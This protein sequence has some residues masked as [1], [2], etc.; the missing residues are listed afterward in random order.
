MKS[1]VTYADNKAR[2]PLREVNHL[3][4]VI[5]ID[6]ITNICIAL[7]RQ[8]PR[9]ALPGRIVIWMDTDD[10]AKNRATCGAAIHVFLNQKGGMAVLPLA[11]RQSVLRVLL[12]HPPDLVPDAPLPFPP[13]VRE[14]LALLILGLQEQVPT[15]GLQF[16]NGNGNHDCPFGTVLYD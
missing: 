11:L 2:L 10:I 4:V 8:D 13:K 14:A 12:L 16:L 15:T 7:H 5:R 1:D 3:S 9:S 6:R